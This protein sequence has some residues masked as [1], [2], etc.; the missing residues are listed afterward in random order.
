MAFNS[1]SADVIL[2]NCTDIFDGLFDDETEISDDN[3]L[4]C[5]LPQT[6]VLIPIL[7][8]RTL[9][10]SGFKTT[11]GDCLLKGKHTQNLRVVRGHLSFSLPPLLL[12]PCSYVFSPHLCTISRDHT[13]KPTTFVF[14]VR[15]LSGC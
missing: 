7:I 14:K 4:A 1:G 13:P 12:S 11:Q 3:L 5:I 9:H 6:L 15:Q 10:M 8:M 2:N